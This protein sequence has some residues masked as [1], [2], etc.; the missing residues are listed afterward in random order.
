M[1]AA[2]SARRGSRASPRAAANFA[3]VPRTHRLSDRDGPRPPAC[4]GGGGG[5]SPTPGFHTPEKT[6]GGEGQEQCSREGKKKHPSP[7]ARPLSDFHPP[8]SRTL[9]FFPK[10]PPPARAQ[11]LPGVARRQGR[12]GAS[13]SLR[14]SKDERGESA[15]HAP[16]RGPGRGAEP[17]RAGR[18]DERRSRGGGVPREKEEAA[19]AR[20]DAAGRWVGL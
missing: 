13:P 16:A 5:E 2:F 9:S 4:T 8:V 20:R 19:A 18:T 6:P 11:P 1:Q 17:E 15:P 12:G 10:E 14:L 3:P 7:L